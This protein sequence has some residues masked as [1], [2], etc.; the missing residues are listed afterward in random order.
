MVFF[1]KIDV[2]ILGV[3][4]GNMGLL[5]RSQFLILKLLIFYYSPQIL[6]L[7]LL[8]FTGSSSSINISIPKNF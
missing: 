7:L 8:M 2:T 5:L 4:M 1:D 6:G 3:G